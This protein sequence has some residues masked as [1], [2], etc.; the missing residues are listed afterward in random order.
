MLDVQFHRFANDAGVVSLCR[1]NHVR[2]QSEV[3]VVVEL[4]FELFFWQFDAIAL[5]AREQDFQRVAFRAQCLDRDGFAGLGR[6]DDNRLGCEVEGDAKYVGILH[7]EEAL[8]VQ[9]IGLAAQGTANHLFTQQLG[10]ERT[11]TKDVSH[12]IGIPTFREH[13]HRHHAADL[14]AQAALL[15]NGV[16][17][18]AQQFAVTQILSLAAIAGALDNLALEASN[19]IS[20]HTPEVIVQRL[21]RF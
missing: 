12:R 1:T 4:G 21:A 9:F 19:L 8:L 3:V 20:G 13:G 15:A 10:A 2:R 7:V 16:H 11:N 5:H 17:H 14:L 6:R 18:L